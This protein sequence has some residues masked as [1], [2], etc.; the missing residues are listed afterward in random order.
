MLSSLLFFACITVNSGL[1][2]YYLLPSL[3]SAVVD[4]GRGLRRS[5]LY[6]TCRLD[7]TRERALR[8]RSLKLSCQLLQLVFFFFAIV[9]AYGPSL[10]FAFYQSGVSAAVVSIEALAGMSA[11]AVTAAV[12]RR[13]A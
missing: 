2:V 7:E 6:L 1:I 12:L 9:L 8:R 11:G 5:R 13:R 10:L 4:L 3:T